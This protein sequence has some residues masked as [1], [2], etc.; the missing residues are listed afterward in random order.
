MT[1]AEVD[2]VERGRLQ[3]ALTQNVDDLTVDGSDGGEVRVTDDDVL[4]EQS[5]L[6]LTEKDLRRELS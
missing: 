1:G 5:L 6:R 4:S 3:R 2:V